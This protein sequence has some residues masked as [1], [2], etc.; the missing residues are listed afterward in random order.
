M[1]KIVIV[2][3]GL[4]NLY[5]IEQACIHVGFPPIISG[6]TED[7]LSAD[8]LILPGVG[9]FGVAMQSLKDTGLIE[10][11][12]EYAKLGRPLMGVCLGMQL[13]FEESE[14]FGN[15]VGLGLIKG[16]I[17]KFPK[18]IEDQKIRIPNVGWRKIYAP[19]NISWNETPLR[20]IEQ[21][22]DHVYYI[23]SYY[24]KPKNI[25]DILCLSEYNG[26]EYVSGV[27]CN[28]IWGFQF[29]PEKSGEEGLTIY[30]RFLEI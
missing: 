27:H 4:G 28:N 24:A 9:A 7:I 17:V 8:Y 3:Y 15:N 18:Y 14:E 2:D 30:K 19:A 20:D 12:K 6:K 29:H 10:T 11:I 22:R 21:E 23:H 26:L 16:N 25:E 13:L 1:K 5:S